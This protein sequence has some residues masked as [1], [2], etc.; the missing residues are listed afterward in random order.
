MGPAYHRASHSPREGPSRL[1]QAAGRPEPGVSFPPG[2]WGAEELPV[3]PVPSAEGPRGPLRVRM[4]RNPGAGRAGSL[5]TNHVHFWW[6]TCFRNRQRQPRPGHGPL[7]HGFSAGRSPTPA[8]SRAGA[9]SWPGRG[10]DGSARGPRGA[11]LGAPTAARLQRLVSLPLFAGGSVT[12]LLLIGQRGSRCLAMTLRAE[13]R[14]AERR[15]GTDR[16]G[17]SG[18]RVDAPTPRAGLAGGKAPVPRPPCAE[19]RSLPARPRGDSG[20]IRAPLHFCG[21]RGGA[22]GG[23]GGACAARLAHHP[24]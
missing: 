16:P 3:V 24:V 20:C 1:P 4:C 5:E 11:A 18:L 14:G 10:P 6:T 21:G 9:S 2:R 8:Q 19:P 13:W 15:R 7:L 23:R 17:G 22:C 12:F